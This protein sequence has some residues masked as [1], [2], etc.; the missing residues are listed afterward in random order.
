MKPSRT[1]LDQINEIILEIKNDYYD[2][3]YLI[4][5]LTELIK[6]REEEHEQDKQD[7]YDNRSEW[8]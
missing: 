7:I 3:H 5:E 4:Q 8:Y 6:Q 1:T 2:P